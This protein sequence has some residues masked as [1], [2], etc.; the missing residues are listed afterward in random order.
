[1]VLGILHNVLELRYVLARWS[2]S[3][4]GSFRWVVLGLV[5]LIALTRLAGPASR[6][7]EVVA[8]FAILAAGMAYG[9]RRRPVLAAAGL[10]AVLVAGAVAW[11]HLDYYFV[12]VTYL[13]NLVPFVFLW[14]WSAR[15]LAGRA[16]TAFR[17]VQ[18]AWLLVVPALLLTGTLPV[19][20]I[21]EQAGAVSFA[22]PVAGHVATAAPPA[23]RGPEAA[24]LLAVFAFLQ[25]LHYVFWCWFL[26]RNAEHRVRTPRLAWVGTA[27]LAAV[28][29]IGYA[30]AWT[31][32]KLAYVSLA[33]YHAYIEYAVLALVVFRPTT[34]EA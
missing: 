14:D 7:V 33:S 19:P 23:W 24:R 4:A 8:G 3:F 10:P 31:G 16:R 1:M 11:L 21:D 20:G 26:P 5:T 29:A 6:R 32:T 22:G 2:G 25:V 15:R 9:A 18:T 28:F 30:T 27:A 13:H 12:A 17:A 34:R